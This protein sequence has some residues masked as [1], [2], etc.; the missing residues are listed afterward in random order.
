[1]IREIVEND[2]DNLL[3]LY[4]QLHDNPFPE[5]NDRILGVWNSILNDDNHHIIVAE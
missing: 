2:F 4:M 5:K 3:Q 1:M